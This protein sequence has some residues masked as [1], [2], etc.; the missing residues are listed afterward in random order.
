MAS[1]TT[2]TTALAAFTLPGSPHSAR[3]ARFYVRAALAYHGLGGY[4]DDAEAVASELIA[5][6]VTHAPAPAVSLALTWLEGF[7]ALGIVVTDPCPLP[8]VMRTPARTPSTGAACTSW[9]HCRCAGDGGREIPARPSTRS[10]PGRRD[11][12]EAISDLPMLHDLDADYSP[13]YVKLARI[14]RD[15]IDLRPVP[16]RRL[17]AR[18]QAGNRARRIGARGVARDGDAGRQ[19]LRAPPRPLRPV[20]RHLAGGRV[21]QGHRREAEVIPRAASPASAARLPVAAPATPS[22]RIVRVLEAALGYGC[23]E[24]VCCE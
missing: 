2:E 19:P 7:R 4:A 23:E 17:T 9:R 14:L 13:Q 18:R 15:K 12:M 20:R 1:T 11:P 3:M 21:M 22:S 24:F 5:N 8:P 10:S 16:A 6:A